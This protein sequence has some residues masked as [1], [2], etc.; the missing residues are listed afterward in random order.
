MNE[1]YL[2]SLL[3]GF[4]ILASIF[5][6]YPLKRRFIASLI[7][8]P[9]IFVG[10]F[11]G[12]YFWGNFGAWQY[13]LEHHET[14]KQAEKL[15]SSI[16]NPQE[17][18]KQLRAK[19][20]DTPKSARGW[21]LLGRLYSSQDEKKK[22]VHAFAKAYRLNPDKEQ[23]LVNYAYSLW[24]SA[25]HQFSEQ[26]RGLFHHAL[27]NNPNQPDALAML[28]MDAFARQAYEE[29]IDYWQR[30]LKLAPVESE[31]TQ[32]IRKAIA[33]AEEQIKLKKR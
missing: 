32:A 26:I 31:E 19:L 5:I 27:N 17:L 22:A 30:L 18:I 14:Q 21:Y 12:Y 10:A 20:D 7:I 4:T 29:T 11:S 8:I 3:I 9:V 25:D 28:A 6:V 1:W 15:L 23:Y 24:V 13:A 33:K 16:K 2:L